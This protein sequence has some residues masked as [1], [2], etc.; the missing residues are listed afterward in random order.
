[1]SSVARTKMLLGQSLV[2]VTLVCI[3]LRLVLAEPTWTSPGTRPADLAAARKAACGPEMDP[4]LGCPEPPTTPSG[5]PAATQTRPESTEPPPPLIVRW[6]WFWGA[7]HGSF[8]F[9]LP[10]WGPGAN[11]GPSIG[12]SLLIGTRF[13]DGMHRITMFQMDLDAAWW[14][15]H[16]RGLH[17]KLAAGPAYQGWDFPLAPTFKAQVFI[18]R[19]WSWSSTLA[20]GKIID[21]IGVE[22]SFGFDF[23]FSKPPYVD[24]AGHEI[25]KEA[26][27]VGDVNR[28][29][30]FENAAD[31]KRAQGRAAQG[32]ER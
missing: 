24:R 26:A 9:I 15:V 23:P 22:L 20:T 4:I 27:R 12:P 8:N 31:T 10:A 32:G 11:L 1:M 16:S 13:Y 29:Y 5:S 3:P 28:E 17:L 2:T 19:P 21:A 18:T 30:Q 6:R 14:L 25:S 7:A